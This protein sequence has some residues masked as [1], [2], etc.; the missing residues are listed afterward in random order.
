M[1]LLVCHKILEPMRKNPKKSPPLVPVKTHDAFFK[2]VGS[3]KEVA[4]ELVRFAKK[5]G[6]PKPC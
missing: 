6:I 1:L 2:A 3:I 5:L 4:E